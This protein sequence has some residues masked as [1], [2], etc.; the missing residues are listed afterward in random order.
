MNKI[1]ELLKKGHLVVSV[2]FRNYI[3]VTKL[4]WKN[5]KSV[6]ML[7]YIRSVVNSIVPIINAFIYGEVVNILISGVI[8]KHNIELPIFIL[9]IIWFVIYFISTYLDTL[10]Y[11]VWQKTQ[12][13]L[14]KLY[15]ALF[16]EKLI[17]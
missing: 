16:L 1:R 4:L 10:N 5:D 2:V 3:R 15:T 17:S 9:F 12:L 8:K 7:S 13:L 14:N 11:I 6:L